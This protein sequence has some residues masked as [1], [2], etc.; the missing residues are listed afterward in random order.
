MTAT[1]PT[2]SR[3]ARPGRAV[4]ATETRLFLRE[5]GSLFW[6]LMFPTL[7]LVVLGLV[8]GFDEPSAEFGGVSFVAAYVPVSCLLAAIM[9]G[10]TAMPAVISAYRE[11]QVLRRI[12]TTPARAA[13]VLGAQ[14]A[15]HAATVLVSVVLVLAVGRLAF[16]VPLPAALPAWALSYLLALVAVFTIGAL[17]SGTAPSSR[18]A[19]TVGTVVF[20][21]L[22]FTAGVWYPVS[23]MSGLVRD[24]VAATPTGAAALA[25]DRAQAG[26]LPTLLQV[27][28]VAGWAVVLAVLAV[29]CFRWQ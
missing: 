10:V 26:E 27:L 2:G 13:H 15:L 12:A 5:P 25:L 19:S 8:P 3:R 20:F 1:R 29:R 7:L 4:L 18:A 22:M 23:A 17:V 11:R 14:V 24:V 16:G 9:A 21:P 28:V 6:I